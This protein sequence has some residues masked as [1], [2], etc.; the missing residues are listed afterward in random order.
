MPS[1]AVC[2][3]TVRLTTHDLRLWGDAIY[4]RVTPDRKLMAFFAALLRGAHFL[5]AQFP[6]FTR[7][8]WIEHPSGNEKPASRVYH[9]LTGNN[10]L[11]NNLARY[12]DW[13][14]DYYPEVVLWEAVRRCVRVECLQSARLGFA[15]WVWARL[16]RGF[17]FSKMAGGVMYG[18]KPVHF[19]RER[20]MRVLRLVRVRRDSTRTGTSALQPFRHPTDEDLSSPQRAKIARRGPRYPWGPR[21][22]GGRR[23]MF[24]ALRGRVSVLDGNVWTDAF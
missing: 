23:C 5:G 17:Y 3:A 2:A 1:R 8:Y 6:G 16:R 21:G 18:L 7:G 9:R 22:R 11:I 20:K 15:G 10:Y 19:V 4:G 14:A 24:L 13:A 12:F